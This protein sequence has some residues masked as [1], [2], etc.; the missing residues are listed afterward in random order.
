MRN[1]SNPL[2][3]SRQLS[4]FL[5]GSLIGVEILRISNSVVAIAGQD[6]W[7]A[8]L[9]GSIYPLT[10]VLVCSYIIKKQPDKNLMDI[11]EEYFGSIIGKILP[12]IFTIQ[13]VAYVPEIIK[14]IVHVNS[15]YISPYITNNKMAIILIVVCSITASMGMKYIIPLNSIFVVSMLFLLLFSLM[16]LKAGNYLN[17]LPVFEADTSKILSATYKTTYSYTTLELLLVIPKFIDKSVKI[18]KASVIGVIICTAMYVW[19]VF[20]SIYYLGIEVINKTVWAFVFVND[21]IKVT[22]VTNF[23][24]VFMVLWQG[25]AI[26]T[27]VDEYFIVCYIISY[28]FKKIPIKKLSFILAPIFFL[29]YIIFSKL[30]L[31]TLFDV[32]VPIFVAYN[33]L[34]ICTIAIVTLFKRK[35]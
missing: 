33:I 6:G 23:R 9:L 21:S 15:L 26:T 7:I 22:I 4:F 19:T 30:T 12:L 27:I 20:I 25:I 29:L 32:L 13:F 14:D 17:L 35:I 18:K 34:L 2:M 10:I 8:T 11:C 3:N 31:E 16:A 5:V 28:I 1:N 24:L